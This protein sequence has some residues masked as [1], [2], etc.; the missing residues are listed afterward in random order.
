MTFENYKNKHMKFVNTSYI[1]LTSLLIFVVSCKKSPP[2]PT[3]EYKKSKG[4]FICNE[5]NYTYGNASLSFY[6]PN[7]KTIDNQVFYNAN[8]FPLGDVCMSMTI[9]D[10]LGFLVINN[11]GKIIILNTNTFKHIATITGLTSPR[12]ILIISNTKAYISDL[13]NKNIA[14]FN[15]E[16]FEITGSIRIGNS[17]ENMVQFENRVFAT[18]WSYNNKVYKINT[19]T[20]KLTDSLTVAKQPNSIILDKNNKLWVLSD[21][22]FPGIPGGQDTAALT[23]IDASTFTIEK[24]YKFSSSDAS[25]TQLKINGTKDTLFF[26]NGTWASGGS[27]DFG[28]FRMPV[29]AEFLPD[30]SFIPQEDKLFYGL[31]IDPVTSEIY[32]SD[33][34][35]YLQKGIVFHYKSDAT[36][37]DSFKTDII[38]SYFCF[39]P[40]N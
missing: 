7:T 31:G 40:Q 34:I 22:G 30:I 36:M 10:T 9:K 4:V 37:I 8:D 26:I 25:P 24:T 35:D 38:P 12:Y 5:G 19:D 20:D 13:Y 21:G 17:T 23:K 11:S 1:I 16:T 14:I 18:S 6:E 33:A 28:I 32:V 39:K 2:T 27:F 15:P 29:N 3:V